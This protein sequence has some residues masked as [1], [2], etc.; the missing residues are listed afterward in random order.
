MT[1]SSDDG[2]WTLGVM[3]S[4]ARAVCR[5]R[6]SEVGVG[7]AGC[8]T[9]LLNLVGGGVMY[10]LGRSRE[11]GPGQLR[12]DC[13]ARPASSRQDG[14]VTADDPSPWLSSTVHLGIDRLTYAALGLYCGGEGQQAHQVDPVPNPHQVAAFGRAQTR[15]AP[16]Q[17]SIDRS[18]QI[19]G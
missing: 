15:P 7:R 8:R 17:L 6:V 13:P 5:T 16:Q 10:R 3:E 12:R 4:P 9:L 2:I 14:R 1:V 19:A 11:R 18:H